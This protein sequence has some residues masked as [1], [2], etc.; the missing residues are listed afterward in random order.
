M[1]TGDVSISSRGRVWAFGVTV[2]VLAVVMAVLAAP[3]LARTEYLHGGLQACGAC[4]QDEH[5]DR[6]P[7]TEECTS[8]HAGFANPSATAT[9]YTCH[10]PAQDT[11]TWRSEA[12][13]TT[14]CHLLD[15]T[16]VTHAAH[17]D[18]PA[19]CLTCHPVT[20]SISDPGESPHHLAPPVPAPTVSGFAPISGLRGSV[21]TVTGSG[22]FTTTAVTFGGVAAEYD[23]AS[24]TSLTAIVPAAAVSG[25]IAV[26]NRGGVAASPAPFTVVEPPSEPA[27]AVTGFS[28]LFGNVGTSVTVTGTGF[29][30][31]TAVSFNGVAAW[32]TV[33]SAGQ[34]AAVVPAG[35]TTGP[36]AVTGPTGTGVSAASFVVL[37]QD[38]ATLTLRVSR[39]TL[40]LGRTVRVRGTATATW[41]ELMGEPVWLTVQRK[42][43]GVWTR[44]R[45]TWTPVVADGYGSYSWSYKP[46]KRGA[47]RV[48]AS[49]S[50]TVLHSAAATGW[51]SFRVR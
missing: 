42:V 29:A 3:A 27:P 8:C 46:R 50:E 25:P 43:A 30:G 10:A 16:T 14:A 47:F 24:G 37:E 18:Q 36:V 48:K 21:V 51:A 41:R 7:T 6:M 38:V 26:T 49:L 5:V 22:F 2:M 17:A 32:F 11:S 40:A 13:C 45:T 20:A 34:I 19:A 39:T 44:V 28:P 12:A 35:A 15:G 4:H 9:C 1:A 33:V 23:V 31:T